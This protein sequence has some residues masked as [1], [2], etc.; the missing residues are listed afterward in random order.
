MRSLVTFTADLLS[1]SGALVETNKHGLEAL[2]PADTAR[3]LE[4][5]EHVKL[6]FSREEEGIPVSFDS[7]FFQKMARLLGDRG[8]F[9]AISL[10]T[11]PLR[12]EKLEDRLNEKVV[13]HNAV[14]QVERTEQKRISYLLAYFKYSARSDDR[15]EG[16]VASMINEFNLSVRRPLS[17]PLEFMAHNAGEPLGDAERENADKVLRALA[18]AQQE[19]VKD[20]L[21]DFLLSLER[22]LN[23]DIRRV[24]DYYQTLIREHRQVLEKKASTT[25]EKEK[26]Q[27][28]IEAIERELKGKVQDLIGK[29]SLHLQIEPISFV[30]V[31]T[32]AEVFWLLVKRRKEARS[33]PL[34]YNPILRSLD[35]LPC[36]VCFYPRRGHAACDDRLHFICK[37]CFSPCR[38]CGKNFCGACHPRGCPRCA[39]P[40][41]VA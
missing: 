33:F 6:S 23:R 18:R 8:R 38:R 16:I 17:E 36:E 39:S 40:I 24:H 9:S 20:A 3:M 22:R 25:E 1:E 14:F 28:R 12:P 26:V 21:Q 7:E 35:S 27:S 11:L 19:I 4:T 30:R 34:T 29:Y 15:Q 10:P 32:V 31:E 41:V 2:F 13:L 5:P 37:E